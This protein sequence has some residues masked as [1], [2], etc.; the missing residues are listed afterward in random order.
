VGVAIFRFLVAFA[1]LACCTTAALAAPSACPQHFLDGAPPT[2]VNEKL[3][4]R[5]RKI[6]YEGFA[7]LHSGVTRTPLWSAEHLTRARI[8]AAHGVDRH[9]AFHAEPRL[10]RGDRAELSDYARSGFDRGHM[11]PSGDMPDRRA[12]Q[13]SFSLANMVPQNPNNNRNLWEGIEAAVRGLAERDGSVYVVTGPIFAGA[14]LKSLRGR[15]LVPTGLFKAV[16]D[17]PRHEAG[18]Y[19]VPNAPGNR[20]QAV[21]IARLQA[22]TGIDVFP[23]LPAQAKDAAMT[24]P[25]PTRHSRRRPRAERN[26]SEGSGATVPQPR[27]DAA[28]PQEA[29]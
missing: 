24:L 1:A 12:Q 27:N 5:T 21:S 25:E 19:V 2:L 28:K 3:A 29:R 13:Q 10:P 15:V 26:M 7:V 17:V 8:E 9:N 4:P 14:N 18:A 11:A 16:Y 23:D 22:M 6:C 20:W